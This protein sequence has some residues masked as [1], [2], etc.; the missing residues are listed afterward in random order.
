MNIFTGVAIHEIRVVFQRLRN[1]CEEHGTY[2]IYLFLFGTWGLVHAQQ[3]HACHD[4]MFLGVIRLEFNYV[5]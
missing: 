3:D 2:R 4:T 5:P 1:R